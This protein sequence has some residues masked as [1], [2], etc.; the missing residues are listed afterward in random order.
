MNNALWKDEARRL[1]RQGM[2]PRD[3]AARVGILPDYVQ[4]LAAEHRVEE[5][6][7]TA[8]QN[9]PLAHVFADTLLSAVDLRAD[10]DTIFRILGHAPLLDLL[11]L[12]AEMNAEKIKA[13]TETAT[14]NFPSGQALPPMA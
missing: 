3:V 10:Q 1:L 2:D 7:V 5:R 11:D 6:A 4:K 9:N 12:A 13:A 14:M 8:Y